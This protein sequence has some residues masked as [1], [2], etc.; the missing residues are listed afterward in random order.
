ME[1][2]LNPGFYGTNLSSM[3]LFTEVSVL[4]LL[5]RLRESGEC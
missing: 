2:W 3:F 4:V 5:Q 1:G